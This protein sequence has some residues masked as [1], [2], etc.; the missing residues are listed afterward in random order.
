MDGDDDSQPPR[1]LIDAGA[2]ARFAAALRAGLHR[3]DAA[4][5]AGF[6]LNALYNARARD[7]LFRLACDFAIALCALDDRAAAAAAIPAEDTPTRI[8]PQGNRLLQ[9]RR[10]RWVRFTEERQQIFLNHFAGTADAQAA[11]AAA[12]VTYHAVRAHWRKNPEFAAAWDDALAQAYALLEAEL[13]RQRLQAQARLAENIEPTGEMAQEFERVMKL[14][15]RWDRR[16]GR[17]GPRTRDPLPAVRWTF[18]EAIDALEKKLQ[19]LGVRRGLLPP[20]P[21]PDEE[22]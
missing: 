5:A 1:G 20:P 17:I 8:A 21:Y 12:G 11:A 16:G 19:A 15:T 13:V 2:K 14:L 18:D 3:A 22:A 9:R 4:A 10:M 6:N 7:P